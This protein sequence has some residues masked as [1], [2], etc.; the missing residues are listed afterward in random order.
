MNR[1]SFVE[2]YMELAKIIAKRATCSRL[3]VGT[4]I[5]STDFRKV[6]AVGYNGN[7]SGLDNCCDRDE[8]GNCGCFLENV[9][10]QTNRGEIAIQDIEPGT[11][12]LT[13]LGRYKKVTE[14]LKKEKY[15]GRFVKVFV[16][17]PTD[18]HNQEPFVSTEDHP[19]LIERNGERSWCKAGNVLIG[20]TVF[21]KSNGNNKLI[22][23]LVIKLE[24]IDPNSSTIY[25]L[26]V[27]DDHSFICQNLAVHN[28]LHSEENSIINCDAPRSIEKF[29]FVT[30]LPCVQCAK[31]IINLGNVKKV[32]YETEYRLIDSITLLK[33]VG[34]D[35]E[36]V[37]LT[38]AE[39][40]VDNPIPEASQSPKPHHEDDS[41][42]HSDDCD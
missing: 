20:D 11:L 12:V 27:A 42:S 7:A 5:T 35:V 3:Q 6:L 15:A 10:V 14:V 41:D 1:P 9:K 33:S 37:S 16:E 40:P 18:H 26:E 8:P 4:V 22:N 24:M 31:R 23:S 32:Y 29:I 28:C 39:K 21:L 36:R 38:K 2:V 25:N 19:I 17:K 13:H 30:H 34:I